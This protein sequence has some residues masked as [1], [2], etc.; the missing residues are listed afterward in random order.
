[1]EISTNRSRD[2]LNIV[3]SEFSSDM[4]D[5]HEFR[6]TDP[7]KDSAHIPVILRYVGGSMLP[8]FREGDELLVI[9]LG[10]ALPR[11]GD[12]IAFSLPGET[13]TIVHRVKLVN[14]TGICTQGDASGLPDPWVLTHERIRGRVEFVRGDRGW[15]R[16]RNGRMG[17][18]VAATISVRRVIRALIAPAL[19]P[20]YRA[21]SSSRFLKTLGRTM[22]TK[23]TVYQ[24]PQGP[25]YQLQLYGLTIGRCLPGRKRWRIRTPF[26]LVIDERHLPVSSGQPKILE[27]AE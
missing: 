7:T 12:V 8:T 11:M 2:K 5:P 18:A 20:V 27:T 6:P 13:R 9:P 17:R 4:G 10:Q 23:V 22:P 26:R 1:L 24:R 14:E 16:G 3:V 19:E 15:Y 21:C 25:E